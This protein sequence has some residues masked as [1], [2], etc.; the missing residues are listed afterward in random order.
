MP[1]N[2]RI[3]ALMS[4]ICG[5]VPNHAWAEEAFCNVEAVYG[6]A[7]LVSELP[8]RL[9]SEG[10]PVA[11]QDRIETDGDSR[12]TL[13]CPDELRITIGP[14][15]EVVLTEVDSGS[16]GWAA[17]LPRGIAR[18]A[19]PLFGSARFEVRTPSAV[20]SVR[21]TVWIV[22]VADGATAV[23]VEEGTV[24]VTAGS[25]TVLL[26]TGEGVD[27]TAESALEGIGT[28]SQARID[29]VISRLAFPTQ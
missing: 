5:L 15:S 6:R 17:I 24:D 3:M 12:V 19:R 16:A 20:A 18:F 8:H 9:L 28:W 1:F 4:A 27:V 21:S 29:D 2:Q 13:V 14:G 23:F 25:S 22:D 26:A 11:V 10:T 7:M